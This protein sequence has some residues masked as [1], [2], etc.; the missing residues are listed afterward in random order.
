VTKHGRFDSPNKTAWRKGLWRHL[1]SR[2][3]C[4]PEKAWVGF[5][6][7][8]YPHDYYEAQKHGFSPWNLIGIDCSRKSVEAARKC[9]CLSVCG[10]AYD[11][12]SAWP[13][14]PKFDVLVL[15]Y[16]GGYCR[17]RYHDICVGLLAS[18][19]LSVVAVNLL[20][21]RDKRFI[22]DTGVGS[23]SWMDKSRGVQLI[24]AIEYGH[25][26]YGKQHWGRKRI[27]VDYRELSEKATRP[28]DQ[29]ISG[30]IRAIMAHRTMRRDV[31]LEQMADTLWQ[32]ERPSELAAEKPFKPT[33]PSMSCLATSPKNVCTETK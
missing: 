6:I 24:T 25:R 14:H 28:V 4:P 15:D 33:I 1:A 11:V 7:G 8:D 31:E 20:R 5:F 23:E 17:D 9:G 30:S 19:Q 26:Y 10:K 2:V 16:C 32:T 27:R 22:V 3:L 29:K 21:G 18:S 13:E 12:F